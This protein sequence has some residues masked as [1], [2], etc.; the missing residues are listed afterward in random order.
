MVKGE[1]LSPALGNVAAVM[2]GEV[3]HCTRFQDPMPVFP[4]V[5][6]SPLG[7]G[8]KSAIMVRSVS[9][10]VEEA[11]RLGRC[12]HDQSAKPARIPTV[13]GDTSRKRGQGVPCRVLPG[14]DFRAAAAGP[15]TGNDVNRH[16]VQFSR[17]RGDLPLAWALAGDRDPRNEAQC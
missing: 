3:L 5:D 9:N 14:D 4:R 16:F 13:N 1:A 12:H 7:R 10:F 6:F 2:I 8:G 17:E 15:P 11:N